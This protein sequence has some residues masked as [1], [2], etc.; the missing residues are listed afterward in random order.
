MKCP[1]CDATRVYDLGSR[2]TL[3][4]FTDYY[5]NGL[6]HSHN[7]NIITNL[8]KCSN[9]HVFEI[10]YRTKCCSCDFGGLIE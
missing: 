7:P 10:K 9:G 4:G 6:F 5:E 3:M 2:S 8:Y 1:E